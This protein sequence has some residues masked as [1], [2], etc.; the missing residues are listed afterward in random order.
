LQHVKAQ[1]TGA[2]V[3]LRTV[4]LRNQGTTAYDIHVIHYSFSN[5]NIGQV[6]ENA[7]M[8]VSTRLQDQVED[9]VAVSLP[10]QQSENGIYLPVQLSYDL[11]TEGG[12][13]IVGAHTVPFPKPFRVPFLAGIFNSLT[14]GNNSNLGIEVFFERVEVVVRE[15]ASLVAILAGE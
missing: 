3:G 4:M 5:T 10:D 6:A 13:S 2:V 15:K 8:A 7:G 11:V 12:L 9:A 14:S 1:L